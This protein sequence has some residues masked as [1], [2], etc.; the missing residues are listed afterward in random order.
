MFFLIDIKV[1]S[2]SFCKFVSEKLFDM[3]QE[4]ILRISFAPS[5]DASI[6]QSFNLFNSFS[7]LLQEKF[8]PLQVE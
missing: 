4:F 1:C 7:L 8:V 3:T 6:F 2:N 5:T